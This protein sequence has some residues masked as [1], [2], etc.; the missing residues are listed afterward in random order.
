MTP[1]QRAAKKLADR[2]SDPFKVMD[3]DQLE[4]LVACKGKMGNLV[5]LP[6]NKARMGVINDTHIFPIS[7]PTSEETTTVDTW[8]RALG[9]RRACHSNSLVAS[10]EVFEAT[11][12]KMEAHDDDS[13][14]ALKQL[15]DLLCPVRQMQIMADGCV[16]KRKSVAGKGGKGKVVAINTEEEY[17]VEQGIA[18]QVFWFLNS[19]SR[20]EE[21]RNACFD[22]F[23]LGMATGEDGKVSMHE[24][25]TPEAKAEWDRISAMFFGIAERTVEPCLDD[26]DGLPIPAVTKTTDEGKNISILYDT[27]S[28]NADTKC[29]RTNIVQVSSQDDEEE[30]EDSE[31]SIDPPRFVVGCT[32]STMHQRGEAEA[33]MPRS[34]DDVPCLDHRKFVE[35]PAWALNRLRSLAEA[36]IGTVPPVLEKADD[37]ATNFDFVEVAGKYFT[38]KH[39]E[40][41]HGSDA[42]RKAAM[43]RLSTAPW[44][45]TIVPH[46]LES[47]EKVKRV[48]KYYTIEEK[49]V[50][51]TYF[52][53]PGF[54]DANEHCIDSYKK[55]RRSVDGIIKPVIADAIGYKLKHPLIVFDGAASN[56]K[57]KRK[58]PASSSG[59]GGRG[60]GGGSSSSA[61]AGDMTAIMSLIESAMDKRLESTNKRLKALIDHYEIPDPVVEDA[62]LDDAV[63][64]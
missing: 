42:D 4:Q 51:D 22:I 46:F 27:M 60:G 40:W 50:V 5:F 61:S 38:D 24:T 17:T 11:V 64:E 37:A 9:M 58:A 45:N 63:D 62:T 3:S 19:C 33:T 39:A 10:S 31:E 8:A 12:A 16:H 28:N 23:F 13:R 2:L 25:G 14:A 21:F 20:D 43:K 59:G 41:D 35:L 30:E 49:A 29:L 56:N 15:R 7:N 52:T 34:C 44:R 54:H 32:V 57:R 6:N 18:R 1:E 36:L 55:Y 48:A 26:E 53:C 47:G